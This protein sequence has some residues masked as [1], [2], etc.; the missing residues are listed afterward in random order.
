MG[1]LLVILCIFL[2]FFY[3]IYKKIKSKKMI[4]KDYNRKISNM[5]KSLQKDLDYLRSQLF[6]SEDPKINNEILN[7][8]ESIVKNNKIKN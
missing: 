2:I 5:D 8:I 6:K 7:K 4:Y 1:N 3:Y